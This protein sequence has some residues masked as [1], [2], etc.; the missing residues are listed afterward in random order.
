MTNSSADTVRPERAIPPPSP[1][2]PEDA[3]ALEGAWHALRHPSL[4]ARIAE[5]VGT[6]I[7]ETVRRLPEPVRRGIGEISRRALEKSLDLA[8]ESLDGR[9]ERFASPLV[10]RVAVS[11]TG[12][13]GGMFGLAGLAVELPLST[14]IILRSIAETARRHGEDPS[15]AEVRLGCLQ[16]FALGGGDAETNGAETGYF[17]VR[18]ALARAVS[19]AARHVARSGVTSAG[20]PALVSLISRIAARYSLAVSQKVALQMIPVVGALGGAA[21]N[22]LFIDH[23][24]RIADAHFTIRRLERIYGDEAI[25]LRV[26]RLESGG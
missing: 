15:S 8:L 7:E 2:T 25:R 20:A 6:P 10:H 12:A 11:V 13:A 9:G 26:D 19:E 17:A 24:L 3:A 1:F 4:A 5:A 21:V 16:I 18:T 23:Y 22:A 14:T